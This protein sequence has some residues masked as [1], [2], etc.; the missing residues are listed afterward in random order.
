MAFL[1]DE[2]GDISL[3]Q[4]DSG[5]LVIDGFDTDKNYTVYF[6]V[7]DKNRKPIG[8][9]LYVNSNKQSVVSFNLTGSFTDLLTVNKNEAYA[10]YYYGIKVCSQDGYEDTVCLGNKDIG[11][12]NTIIVYP[13]KVEGIN[14]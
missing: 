5:E 14:E 7:Q 3:I 10:V 13:K 11:E 8:N 2:N 12:I 4:G 9:E 6:A 1:V